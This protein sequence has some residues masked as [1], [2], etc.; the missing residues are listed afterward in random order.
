[1]PAGVRVY[2][3]LDDLVREVSAQEPF[4]TSDSK[5]GSHFERVRYR[6]EPMILKYVSVD[7]DWIMR[8]TGDLD[9]RALRFFS[10][11]L[12]DRIPESIDHTTVAVAPTLSRHGH[13][14]A[15]LLLHDVSAMLIPSGQTRIDLEQH[16][17]FIE[18]MASLHAAFWGWDDDLGL[19]PI[20]HHYTFLTPAMAALEAAG[21]GVDPV[22]PAVASGWRAL[23]Q[24]APAVASALRE[25]ALD[26]GR[27]VVAL[28]ST[29]TTLIHGD[30]KLGNLGA[31]PGGRTILFDWDRVGVAPATCDLAWYIAINCKRL[32]QSKEATIAAYRGSLERQ[33]VAT[34]AWWD[35][36]LALAL[37][38]AGLQLGWEKAGDRAELGWWQDRIV[39]GLD[40]LA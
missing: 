5:S 14:G 3:S 16:L 9:C 11:A 37:L 40:R 18:H 39:E 29:P 6:G 19:M 27:L 1:M 33:G 10:S 12:T 4:L 13:Q 30:W 17:R 2:A 36:Q 32:P 22:P 26:P 21:G 38:G 24:A 35:R 15:A 23:D 25:L 34:T 20:A 8:G 28:A 7:E 31:H